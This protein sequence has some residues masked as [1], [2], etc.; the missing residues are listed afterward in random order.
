MILVTSS[1]SDLPHDDI[2]RLLAWRWFGT[3]CNPVPERPLEPNPVNDFSARIYLNRQR[4]RFRHQRNF[5]RTVK[6]RLE[7][8]QRKR[9]YQDHSHR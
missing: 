6:T 3:V 7:E 9:C 8:K 4:L 2:L 1:G 5:T